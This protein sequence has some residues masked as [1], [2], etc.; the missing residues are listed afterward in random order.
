M[1]IIDLR[2]NE[3]TALPGQLFQTTQEINEIS[4][5]YNKMSIL[6]A[7]LFWGLKNLIGLQVRHNRLTFIDGYDLFF[8]FIFNN[9][10]K[11]VQ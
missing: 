9:N 3:L 10:G 4:L 6:N 7:T 11:T 8:K 1:K 5:C 2:K